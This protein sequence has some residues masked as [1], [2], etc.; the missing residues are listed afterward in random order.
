MSLSNVLQ[1]TTLR[2]LYHVGLSLLSGFASS[3]HV[4][5]VDYHLVIH[6]SVV[7]ESSK[8]RVQAKILKVDST[9]DGQLG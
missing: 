8:I 7:V 4:V 9:V 6:S 5:V 1:E 2:S 3:R